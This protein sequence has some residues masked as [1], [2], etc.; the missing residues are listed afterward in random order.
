MKRCRIIVSI[1]GNNAQES[2]GK[3]EEIKKLKITEVAL[4]LECLRKPERA[5]VY[6]AL[7]KSGIKHIPLVH[8]RSDMTRAE[9]AMLEKVYGVKYFTI[10][11]EHFK[12]ISHW[13]GF[14]KKLYLEMS[15]DNYVAPNV[16]VE[17]IGGFCV[18]L[19]HYKKQSTLKN[20]D[21]EY[22]NSRRS[23]PRLFACNHLS[24]YDPKR[25]MDMHVV[26][27]KKNF[28]YLTSLPD[29]IFGKLIAIEL[30]ETI[31]KQLVFKDHVTLLIASRTV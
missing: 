19:A 7:L 12:I 29:F 5:K 27:S 28:F 14:Y 21:Y 23:N 13:K 6:A 10:H 8:L 2:L 20:K 30:D 25:N 15:T 18:D 17:K 16:K 26:K 3:I 4:F 31:K 22:V 1:T 24:G 11:E 9:V